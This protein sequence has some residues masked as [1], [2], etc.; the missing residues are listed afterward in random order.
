MK[1]AKILLLFAATLMMARS[2]PQMM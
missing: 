1:A 2:F